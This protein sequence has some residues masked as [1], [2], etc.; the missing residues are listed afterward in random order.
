VGNVPAVKIVF[1]GRVE[2]GDSSRCSSNDDEK[3]GALWI[4]ARD[5]VSEIG[6]VKWNGPVTC[7]IFAGKLTGDTAFQGAL[8]IQEGWGYSEYTPIES[9]ELFVG[10]HNLL[11]I[12]GDLEGDE[13]TVWFADEPINVLA[14]VA[15]PPSDPPLETP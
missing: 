2:L 1:E 3:D 5:V 4:G 12:I 10:P 14:G 11:K 9:D 8:R 13:I 6:E 7:A 15:A